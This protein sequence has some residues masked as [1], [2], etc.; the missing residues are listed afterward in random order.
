ME[1]PGSVPIIEAIMVT[2]KH[3]PDSELPWRVYNEHN[4]ICAF[5]REFMAEAYRIQLTRAVRRVTG[6]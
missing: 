5:V 1:L 4:L 2:I 6:E 3:Q